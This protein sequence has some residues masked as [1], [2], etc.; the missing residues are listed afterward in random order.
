MFSN[1]KTTKFFLIILFLLLIIIF[2]EGVYLLIF[3]KIKINT[4]QIVPIGQDVFVEAGK[5]IQINKRQL[6]VSV[7]NYN[8]S[9]NIIPSTKFYSF[10]DDPLFDRYL[11]KA[12][13]F[14]SGNTV[15]VRYYL[16]NNKEGQ[17][18]ALSISKV[19]II[20]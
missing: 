8:I 7:G 20:K 5:I 13:D 17:K 10:K 11:A 12:T 6:I 2:F 4:K 19:K 1:K 14:N 3:E 16:N 15:S 9:F 18:I